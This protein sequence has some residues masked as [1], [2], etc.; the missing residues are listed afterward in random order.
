[1]SKPFTLG[2]SS[3]LA[4]W[5]H[6]LEYR[7]GPCE[8]GHAEPFLVG[9]DSV[10][11]RSHMMNAVSTKPYAVINLVSFGSPLGIK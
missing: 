9:I 11:Y 6:Q 1:M 10:R 3:E 4:F 5:E 7:C 2:D 8:A